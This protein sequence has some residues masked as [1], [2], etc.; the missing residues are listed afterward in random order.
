MQVKDLR[1]VLD[2][3]EDNEEIEFSL[4]HGFGRRK[5]KICA[6]EP[7]EKGLYLELEEEIKMKM[8]INYGDLAKYL[9]S[10]KNK[11][12]NISDMLSRDDFQITYIFESYLEDFIENHYNGMHLEM[13]CQIL[14]SIDAAQKADKPFEY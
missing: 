10:V 1:K 8:D 7:Q 3:F 2:N 6:A 11:L 13:I 4:V 9:R 12:F 14:E 5:L